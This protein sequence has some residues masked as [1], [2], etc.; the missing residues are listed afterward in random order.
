MFSSAIAVNGTGAVPAITLSA[1]MPPGALIMR[2]EGI[3]LSRPNL[4]RDSREG[5]FFTLRINGRCR[6]SDLSESLQVLIKDRCQL[7]LNHTEGGMDGQKTTSD[8]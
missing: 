8:Y 7:N 5:R 6:D 4:P 1:P 3:S 2:K